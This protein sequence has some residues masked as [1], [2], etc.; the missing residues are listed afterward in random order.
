MKARPTR[1]PTLKLRDE[2]G[3]PV[4]QSVRG[5]REGWSHRRQSSQHGGSCHADSVV[6]Q[7]LKKTPTRRPQMK[8]RTRGGTRARPAAPQNRSVVVTPKHSRTHRHQ[9][10]HGRQ[11]LPGS[12]CLSPSPWRG[13][14]WRSQSVTG[15]CCRKKLLHLQK[16]KKRRRRR[17]GWSEKPGSLTWDTALLRLVSLFQTEKCPHN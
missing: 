8:R 14:M 7:T 5:K 6:F 4:A 2:T 3:A 15:L 10:G 16:K 17:R 12:C 13:W 9:S 11:L 1:N